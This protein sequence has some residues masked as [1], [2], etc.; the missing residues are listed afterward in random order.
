MILKVLWMA[1]IVIISPDTPIDK[2]IQSTSLVC[3]A[4]LGITYLSKP[5]SNIMIDRSGLVLNVI[6]IWCVRE[7]IKKEEVKPIPRSLGHEI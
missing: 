5:E 2:L 3:R 4:E 7:E 6:A 1:V